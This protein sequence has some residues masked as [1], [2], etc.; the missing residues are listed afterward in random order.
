[1]LSELNNHNMVCKST[2]ASLFVKEV[3]FARQEKCMLVF[4]SFRR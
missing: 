1:M 4:A 2:K 3:Q